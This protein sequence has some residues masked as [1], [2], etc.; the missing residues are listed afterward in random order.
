M[1]S[2]FVPRPIALLDRTVY[3]LSMSK[4]FDMYDKY[5]YTFVFLKA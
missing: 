4:Q 1:Y 3:K 2:Q 5:I